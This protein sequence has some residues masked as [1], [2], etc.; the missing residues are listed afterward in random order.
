MDGNLNIGVE[1]QS[2]EEDTNVN[3]KWR[4]ERN[5]KIET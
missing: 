3:I 2:N 5:Y 4:K 1:E